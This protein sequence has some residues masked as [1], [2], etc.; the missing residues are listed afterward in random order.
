[1]LFEKT[2]LQVSIRIELVIENIK[3]LIRNP[4]RI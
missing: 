4:Q 1:M 3:R 2:P